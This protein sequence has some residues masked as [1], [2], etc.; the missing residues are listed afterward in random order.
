M[1]TLGLSDSTPRTESRLKSLFWPTIQTANDMDYLGV[2]GYWVC[3]LVAVWALVASVLSSQPITGVCVFLF[4]YLGGVG[5]REHSRYAAAVVFIMYVGDVV[6]SGPSALKVLVAALLLSNFRAT[7]IASRWKPDS[8]EAIAP[9]RFGDTWSDKFAD[10]FPMWL[11]P[12]LRLPYYVFS[13]GFLI[14]VAV[15]I[16]AML[17]HSS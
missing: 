16:A 17:H 7:W 1:Q 4:Y 3:A 5:V 8:E 12:K 11:W 15:G 14:L 13:A 6:V 2:Q 9:P 10:Q